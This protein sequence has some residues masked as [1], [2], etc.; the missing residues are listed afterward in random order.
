MN[1]TRLIAARCC[2]QIIDK[3]R[4]LD[5]V[6]GELAPGDDKTSL[7]P[8]DRSFVKELVFGVCRW[9]GHLEHLSTKL[10]SKPLRTKDRDIHYLLLVG[11]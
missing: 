6:L 8:A 2:L 1:N 11:L 3:G 4:S 10:L 9:H 7:S 5:R